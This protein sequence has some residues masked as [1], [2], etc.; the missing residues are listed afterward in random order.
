[1]GFEYA[2]LFLSRGDQA[3]FPGCVMESHLSSS[4]QCTDS[5]SRIKGNCLGTRD[6]PTDLTGFSG[7][8]I[9]PTR[10]SLRISLP[11]IYEGYV[12]KFA[13]HEGLKLIFSGNLT[14]DERSTRNLP[15]AAW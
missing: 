15:R 12:T 3:L 5:L 9:Q 8:R 6:R 10:R 11:Q 2:H 13:P 7:Q 4:G 1:M 14:F